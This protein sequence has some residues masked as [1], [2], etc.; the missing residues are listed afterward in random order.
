RAGRLEPPGPTS[1]RPVRGEAD[2]EQDLPRALRPQR[3]PVGAERGYGRRA[4]GDRGRVLDGVDT[5][6]RVLHNWF[7]VAQPPR[8]EARLGAA[9]VIERGARHRDEADRI[10]VQP[11]LISDWRQAPR[12]E[13]GV[14]LDVEL[15]LPAAG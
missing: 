3:H 9:G 7:Q 11:A 14:V 8:D 12:V 10:G 5:P 6:V 13:E 1:E 15:P 4:L 2:A